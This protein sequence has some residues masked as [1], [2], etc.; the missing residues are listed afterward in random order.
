MMLRDCTWS[1]VTKLYCTFSKPFCI[2]SKLSTIFVMSIV[3][4]ENGAKSSSSDWPNLSANR[5]N[6]AVDAP[7]GAAMMEALIMVA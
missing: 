5:F 2:F 7:H 4:F 3:P 1:L 6:A